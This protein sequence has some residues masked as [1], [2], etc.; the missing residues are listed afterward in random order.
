MTL[1]GPVSDI[2][3]SIS[4]ANAA[5][6]LLR[7][8][9]DAGADAA[10][11]EAP[12]SRF[13]LAGVRL[14]TAA[15]K[16]SAPMRAT[17]PAPANVTAPRAP[18]VPTAAILGANDRALAESARA[19]AASAGSLD[20]LREILQR[21]E[22]IESLRGR[23]TNM[24]FADGNPESR[25]MLVGEAPGADEDR[26]GKPF[27]GV[28]GQLLDRMLGSIGLDRTSFYITNICFWRPPGNRKPTEAELVAQAPFVQRHIELVKPRV[29]VLVGASSAHALLGTND[30]ITRLRGRWFDYKSAG[31]ANAVPAL[32][33]FH[34]AFLLRQPAQKRETWADLLKLK[35]R[36][37]ELG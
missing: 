4:D 12:I 18:A 8:N 32:P 33:I 6:A 19:A 37:A 26:L 35:S 31:L 7:F 28:S 14:E 23:A 9:L 20:E 2:S 10:I 29:L 1:S 16:A 22:G 34:P 13:G 27:V 30:G 36:L 21:F 11:E 25:V 15:P 24:V 5:L 3:A 17:D